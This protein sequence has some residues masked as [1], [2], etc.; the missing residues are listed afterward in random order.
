MANHSLVSGKANQTISVESNTSQVSQLL[1]IVSVGVFVAVNFALAK[2]SV[3]SGISPLVVLALP[4]LG[5][6]AILLIYLVFKGQLKSLKVGHLRY[7]VVAGLLGVSLPNLAS[8]FALQELEASTFSVLITLSPLFTLL[9]SVPFQKQGL[10]FNRI[11][12]IGIGFVAVSLVTLSPEFDL[13]DDG[14]ILLL[15]LSV[16]LFLAMGN[17]YRSK[18]CPIDSDP[19]ALA[20]GVLCIQSLIWLPVSLSVDGIDGIYVVPHLN[21]LILLLMA[22]ISASSYLLTF[23]LQKL[24][25]GL[26]FSQVGNVVTVTGVGIGILFFSETF[27]YRLIIALVLLFV[28]LALTNAPSKPVTLFKNTQ[29]KI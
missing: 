2:Y 27:H 7:Y 1:Y 16:P 28:G 23:K 24:T 15:A 12:G 9:L 18:A 10:S 8:N 20:T 11:I 29:R 26:G 14:R 3:M 25:D 19:I 5:A 21:S 4:L 6:A 13:K 17:I 22:L